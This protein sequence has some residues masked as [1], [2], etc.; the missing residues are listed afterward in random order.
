MKRSTAHIPLSRHHHRALD[1]ARRLRRATD[2]DIDEVVRGFEAFWQPGGR[3]HF[4]VEE[5]LLLP[6]VAGY[7]DPEWAQ[8]VERVRSEHAAIRTRAA[9]LPTE[10]RGHRLAAAQALGQM[11][12]DHVRFE[13]RQL[14]VLLEDRLSGGR[15][16]QLGDALAA[17]NH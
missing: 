11:L 9:A 7:G 5:Q 4:D 1:V 15:L 6:A 10:A 13:E 2:D 14:F 16:V 17:A 8:A 3:R 12:H